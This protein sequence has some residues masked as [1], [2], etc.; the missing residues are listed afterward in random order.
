MHHAV[1]W[2]GFS[3]YHNEV[4]MVKGC[5]Q[6]HYIYTQPWGARA[7]Q[8]SCLVLSKLGTEWQAKFTIKESYSTDYWNT[9]KKNETRN[10]L[11][12]SSISKDQQR[13]LVV[14]A[15]Y[16]LIRIPTSGI[17]H[18]YK[19]KVMDLQISLPRWLRSSEDL[20][21]SFWKTI[22]KH[23]AAISSN[24]EA[25]IEETLWDSLVKIG[26]TTK[27]MHMILLDAYADDQK[28]WR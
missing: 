2:W 15:C 21:D 1:H 19:K 3:V 20:Y 14:L 12:H 27:T 5:D 6:L 13:R 28:C 18:I 4:T 23:I 24:F 9:K 10:I 22:W 7:N 11:K 8:P 17:D 25:Y 16:G 26:H